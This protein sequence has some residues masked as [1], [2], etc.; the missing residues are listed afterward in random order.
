MKNVIKMARPWKADSGARVRR[1]VPRRLKAILTARAA[2][3]GEPF[4]Q[5]F[6]ARHDRRQA[7]IVLYATAGGGA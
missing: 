7:E 4:V 1:Y 3:R 6:V 2:L 5:I